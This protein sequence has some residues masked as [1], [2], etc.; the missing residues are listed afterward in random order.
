MARERSSAGTRLLLLLV[1]LGGAAGLGAWNYQRNL[2]AERAEVRPYRGLSDADLGALI[3]A[4]EGEAA[5]ASAR[6]QRAR[7]AGAPPAAPAP[8]DGRFGAFERIQQRGRAVRELGYEAAGHETMLAQ[9]REEQGRRAGQGSEL[10]VF[11][12]RVLTLR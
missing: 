6:Y 9:L 1:L 4:V 3:D 11:L 12:R 7:S 10:Q 2:E 5:R 8:G